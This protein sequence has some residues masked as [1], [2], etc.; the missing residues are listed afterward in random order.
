MI[1]IADV[2]RLQS[3]CFP[4]M[5][6]SSTF[7]LPNLPTPLYFFVYPPKV[8]TT[9]TGVLRVCIAESLLLHAASPDPMPWEALRTL[10]SAVALLQGMQNVAAQHAAT[11]AAVLPDLTA[12]LLAVVQVRH[13]AA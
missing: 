4:S 9:L 10:M 1:I 13:V 6:S 2:Y 8:A 5:N 11:V 3:P 7:L 12:H